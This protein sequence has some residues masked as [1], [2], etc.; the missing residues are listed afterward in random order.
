MSF[1]AL[2]EYWK[3][4]LDNVHHRISPPTIPAEEIE[5]ELQG[6]SKFWL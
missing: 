6:F 5:K 3:F 2:V 1:K 4:V